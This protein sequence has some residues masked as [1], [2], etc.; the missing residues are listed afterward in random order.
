[1][2]GFAFDFTSFVYNSPPYKWRVFLDGSVEKFGKKTKQIYTK[3]PISLVVVC[4]PRSLR[5]GLE[6]TSPRINS[7]NVHLT[8]VY[9]RRGVYGYLTQG[10]RTM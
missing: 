8:Y 10:L 5:F 6:S 7:K 1:M 3:V 2:G 4:V 9:P